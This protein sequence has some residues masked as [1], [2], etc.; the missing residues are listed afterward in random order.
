MKFKTNGTI[1]SIY[2]LDYTHNV[3]FGGNFTSIGEFDCSKNATKL[4]LLD[5]NFEYHGDELFRN[6][7]FNGVITCIKSFLDASNNENLIVGGK[8]WNIGDISACNIAIFNLKTNQWSQLGNNLNNGTSGVVKCI[9]YYKNKIIVGGDFH[10]VNNSRQSNPSNEVNAKN[11]AIFD[12]DKK[13][14]YPLKDQY[15]SNGGGVITINEDYEDVLCI[16]VDAN[17]NTIYIG[18]E[19]SHVNNQNLI[20]LGKYTKMIAKF[21]IGNLNAIDNYTLNQWDSVINLKDIYVQGY[22]KIR[23]INF[24]EKIIGGEFEGIIYNKQV[25]NIFQYSING[26]NITINNFNNGLFLTAPMNGRVYSIQMTNNNY[27]FIGGDFNNM[28]SY[29]VKYNKTTKNLEQIKQSNQPSDVIKSLAWVSSDSTKIEND[30]IIGRLF[31]GNACP[32]NDGLIY[33]MEIKGNINL[34]DHKSISFYDIIDNDLSNNTINLSKYL[35]DKVYNL[36]SLQ[37][38]CYDTFIKP[39]LRTKYNIFIKN[40]NNTV[41]P[42]LLNAIRLD[43]IIKIYDTSLNNQTVNNK[44]LFCLL[45]PNNN[46][47]VIDFNSY[48]LPLTCY[49]SLN[50]NETLKAKIGNKIYNLTYLNNG[51]TQSIIFDNDIYLLGDN[52][53]ENHDKKFYIR[54]FG[55][56]LADLYCLGENTKVLTSQGYKLISNITKDDHVITSDM[57]IVKIKKIIKDVLE[58]SIRTYAYLIPK[59]SISKNYPPEDIELSTDHLIKFKDTWIHPQDKKY[60]FKRL[61]TNDPITYYHIELEN[62]ESDHLVINGGA[63]VESYAGD[64]KKNI[65]IYEKRKNKEIYNYEFNNINYII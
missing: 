13:T 34:P 23:A 17:T 49:F 24:A 58:P 25:N 64:N 61:I 53:F 62:Y 19:F 38:S 33:N 21:T 15:S 52:I 2:S 22:T 57:R 48:A 27:G 10:Y 9:Y 47:Q 36:R 63:I 1:N 31:M 45:D 39:Y 8:F 30:I 4:G 35:N 18:G 7:N 55:S 32:V 3:F 41:S 50:H 56:L 26:N 29:L 14:W 12:L 28:G 42:I 46:S 20:N 43:S 6:N 37:F 60:N 59:Y 65:K 16:D 51:I 54:G 40:N 11:I 44:I 5:E